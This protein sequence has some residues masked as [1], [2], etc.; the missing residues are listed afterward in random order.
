MKKYMIMS[1]D[2]P[3]PTAR[4]IPCKKEFTLAV[5]LHVT[6]FGPSQNLEPSSL[7]PETCLGTFSGSR[8]PLCNLPEHPGTHPNTALENTLAETKLHAAARE[9]PH[10]QDVYV[11]IFQT[12]SAQ[13]EQSMLKE[14]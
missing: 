6:L 11:G 14:I 9:T 4:A 7:L 5:L 13:G 12:I 1:G 8:E 10:K 3:N 2:I